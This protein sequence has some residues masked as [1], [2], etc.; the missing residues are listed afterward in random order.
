[1]RQSVSVNDCQGGVTAPIGFTAGGLSCGIRKAKK[2]LGMVVSSSPATVA[3]VFTLNKTQAAPV[4]V[5]KSQLK[6]SNICSAVVIN[7]GNA[8][9]CTGERGLNDA[10]NMVRLTAQVL[11]LP[12]EQIMVSSTGVIGQY[13]PM[14]KVAAGIRQLAGQLSIEGSGEAAHSI[15]TTDTYSKEAAVRFSLGSAT[16]TIGGMAKGSGMIAPNMMSAKKS[17]EANNA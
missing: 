5:D 10:W 3:G 16:V 13:L 4:V 9:A 2:D 11:N 12:E 8:N 7:S 17:Y 15:M 14:E 6:R 1:M